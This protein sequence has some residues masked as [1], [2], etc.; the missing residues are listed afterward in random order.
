MHIFPLVFCEF[1][2]VM[3]RSHLPFLQIF[4]SEAPL[5]FE[6]Y[7]SVIYEQQKKNSL[8]PCSNDEKNGAKTVQREPGFEAE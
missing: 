5:I 6:V 1:N 8:N 4:L 2:C 3:L 7:L